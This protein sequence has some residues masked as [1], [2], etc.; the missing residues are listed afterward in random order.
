MTARLWTRDEL[1]VA[2]NLSCRTPFDKLHRRNRDTIA[3]A[4]QIG[5]SPGAVAMKLAAFAG[6][7][8][9]LKARNIKGR[10]NFSKRDLEVWE[11]FCSNWEKLAYES[12]KTWLR[13]QDRYALPTA[14][15]EA[16]YVLP[17]G[18]TETQRLT[19]VRLV[20]GFFRDATLANYEFKC[21]FCA[22]NVLALLSASHIIPWKDDVKRR[23]DPTN[24]LCLCALHDRAFDRGLLGLDKN[25]RILVSPALKTKSPSRIHQAALLEIEGAPMLRPRRFQP[26]QAAIEFHRSTIFRAGGSDFEGLQSYS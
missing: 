4:G 20:Q 25:H 11:E 15:A 1:L 21:A 26:D 18:E 5:R 14:I 12:Q 13:F 3:L 22:L 23:A 24:G 10:T 19:R 7:D 8:A 2:I 16:Q 17:S 9:A 6:L